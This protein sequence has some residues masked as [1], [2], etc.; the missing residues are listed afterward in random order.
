MARVNVFLKDEVLSAVDSEA[1]ASK[2]NRSALIRARAYP[3]N[4]PSIT[5]SVALLPARMKLFAIERPESLNEA[6]IRSRLPASRAMMISGNATKRATVISRNTCAIT[7]HL[8]DSSVG[9]NAGLRRVVII[10]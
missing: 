3:S 6:A 4:I 8:P 9:L 1:E 10:W 2:V 5:A 7:R